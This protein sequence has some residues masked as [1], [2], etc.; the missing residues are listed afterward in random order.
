MALSIQPAKATAY[1]QG[2]LPDFVVGLRSVG[3]QGHTPLPRFHPQNLE[4]NRGEV[5]DRM[6]N[7][8]SAL[9]IGKI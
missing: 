2:I 7:L 8:D 4:N 5:I 3:G 1:R 9:V 6:Q